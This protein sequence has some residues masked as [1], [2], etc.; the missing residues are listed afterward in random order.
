MSIKHYFFSVTISLYGLSF[1][2]AQQLAFSSNARTFETQQTSLL[3][4]SLAHSCLTIYTPDGLPCA[5]S[6][7]Y[8]NNAPGIMIVGML[9]NGISTL[10]NVQKLLKNQINDQLINDLFTGNNIIQIEENTELNFVSKYFNA[11]YTP[12]AVKSF[13]VIRNEA[14]P[15]VEL[16]AVQQRGFAFQGN[17]PLSENFIAGL[18]T[19]FVDRK[20]IR[21]RFKLVQL[22]TAEG[23]NL[24]KPKE[25]KVTYIEPSL[26]WV[27]QSTW[28][29]RA[30][31]M[32][33]NLGIY[34]EEY[35]ELETP[36]DVQVGVGISPTVK[37]GEFELSLE[38]RSMTYRESDI[39]KLRLG[40]MY[41][42]GAMYLAGGLDTNGISGGIYYSLEELSAGIM[43]S[44]TKIA[45]NDDYFS[46]TVYVQ[47]GWQI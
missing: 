42:L 1:A 28:K 35:I 46:Q 41:K 14:N 26:T 32:V 45:N 38:Y 6:L 31:L 20:F 12:L 24:L 5:P 37:W 17:Y 44:T 33:S 19:R 25:Q 21:Q 22:G 2:H 16:Y 27:S 29:P 18:Q 43:Y 9:S 11:R 30:T 34:S 13:A 40:A 23:K 10:N 39:E 4:K 3:A 36:I 15:D 8:K 7:G 47:L